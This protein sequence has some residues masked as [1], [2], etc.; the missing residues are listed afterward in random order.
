M[1][2]NARKVDQWV[3]EAK[4]VEREVK[5]AHEYVSQAREYVENNYDVPD[6]GKRVEPEVAL[7]FHDGEELEERV[8]DLYFGGMLESQIYRRLKYA[9][10]NEVAEGS[11]RVNEKLREYKE[12]RESA[13]DHLEEFNEEV[14]DLRSLMG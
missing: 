11:G 10:R 9:E 6:G 8:D 12:T 5:Q 3:D 7:S 13:K 14:E 4:S 2:F 1:R